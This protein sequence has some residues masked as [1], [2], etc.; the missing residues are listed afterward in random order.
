MNILSEFLFN[1]L[2]VIC[3]SESPSTMSNLH[4][5]QPMGCGDSVVLFE[6]VCEMVSLLCKK[7]RY[8]KAVNGDDAQ[9]IR[10]RTVCENISEYESKIRSMHHSNMVH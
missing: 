8:V 9:C 3:L 5:T 1:D 2:D 7:Y 10:I 6:L 4:N